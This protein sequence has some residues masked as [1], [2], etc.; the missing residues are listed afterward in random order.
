VSEKP[1]ETLRRA[2]KLMRE[3]AEAATPGPW[4]AH[5]DYVSSGTFG[6]VSTGVNEDPSVA[7]HVLVER[8]HRDAEHMAGMDP[9][10]GLA[11][12]VLFDRIAW[13][14]EIDADLTERVGVPETLAV[15]RAYLGEV[16]A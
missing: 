7:D 12:A 5:E 15:A 2:A 13:M 4:H 1:A 14:V 3:R 10:V 6:L 11:L 9:L 8:D 16:Q